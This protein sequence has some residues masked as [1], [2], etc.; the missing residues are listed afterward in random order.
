[1]RIILGNDHGG[2]ELKSKIAAYLADYE[3]IDIGCDS[4]ESCDYPDYVHQAIQNLTD[5][6]IAI[7]I[8][9]S[10]NGVCMT[11]NKYKDVRAALCWN[12]E[13]A[14][15][16]RQHNDANVLCLPARFISETEAIEMVK[17]FLKTEFEGGRHIKRIEKINI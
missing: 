8:C 10:G 2:Y 12:V 9:G 13:I 11:A 7:L 17:V 6:T 15:L 14:K 3:I 4:T 1:M 16:A 5:S